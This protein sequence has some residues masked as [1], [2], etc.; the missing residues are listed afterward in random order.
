MQH[1][2]LTLKGRCIIFNFLKRFFSIKQKTPKKR[3][4]QATYLNLC[5]K[6]NSCNL[7]IKIPFDDPQNA[8]FYLRLGK[9]EF[10]KKEHLL[11]LRIC[12]Y[13]AGI[14][15]LLYGTVQQATNDFMSVLYIDIIECNKVFPNVY[16]KAFKEKLTLKKF[17]E[18]FL[19]NAHSLYKVL[20]FNSPITPEQAW[21]KILEY[22]STLE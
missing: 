20:Q 18:I 15:Q 22:R 5:K 1:D 2:R 19:A 8:M 16:K 6:F 7:S 13:Y 3:T 11:D 12:R 21:Q 9:K 4:K 10:Y 14:I 17:E